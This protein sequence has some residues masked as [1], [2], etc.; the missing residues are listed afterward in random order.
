MKRNL[1]RILALILACLMV[2]VMALG[3]SSGKKDDGKDDNKPVNTTSPDATK[4]GGDATEPKPDTD[5][6]DDTKDDG[7]NT[8]N[9]DGDGLYSLKN[10]VLCD[11]DKVLFRID[12]IEFDDFWESAKFNVTCENKT[13]GQVGFSIGNLVLNGCMRST[14]FLETADAGETVESYF[15]LDVDE[16]LLGEPQ[17]LIIGITVSDYEDIFADALVKENVTVYMPGFD[18]SNVKYPERKAVDGE[19]AVV[20]TDEYTVIVLGVDEDSW[21]VPGLKV[22]Y[23]NKTDKDVKFDIDDVE[24]GGKPVTSYAGSTVLAGC[25]GYENLSFD[26]DDD[27]EPTDYKFTVMVSEDTLWAEPFFEQECTFEP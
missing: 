21:G 15:N 10:V 26:G 13:D 20:D 11:N 24:I 5:A 3:C 22:Y 7:G 1:I 14:L 19:K 16:D 8:V 27:I 12:S 2:A 6:P 9:T 18:E 17:E 23:E 4:D 25:C